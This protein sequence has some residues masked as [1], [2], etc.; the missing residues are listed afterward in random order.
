MEGGVGHTVT[1]PHTHRFSPSVSPAHPPSC[2]PHIREAWRKGS[3]ALYQLLGILGCRVGTMPGERGET[4]W[5]APPMSP[6]ELFPCSTGTKAS[7]PRETE[8]ARADLGREKY[9]GRAWGPGV[10]DSPQPPQQL[11]IQ[12][13]LVATQTGEET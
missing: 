1:G 2:G 8:Q 13:P 6:P 7:C 12:G 10:L 4:C 3:E 11:Q 5:E 9:R